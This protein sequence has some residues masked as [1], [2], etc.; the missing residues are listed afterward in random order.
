MA[1][2]NFDDLTGKEITGANFGRQPTQVEIAP[3]LSLHIQ[4]VRDN[5]C[6]DADIDLDSFLGA[7]DTA[8]R[9]VKNPPVVPETPAVPAK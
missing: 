9:Q 3:G 7:L 6:N 5:R 2:K 8:K 4:F 1:L